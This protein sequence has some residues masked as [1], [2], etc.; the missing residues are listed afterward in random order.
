MKT[1]RIPFILIILFFSDVYSN[2]FENTKTIENVEGVTLY[3]FEDENFSSKNLE[4]SHFLEGEKSVWD[5][6]ENGFQLN[7][8]SNKRVKKY[9]SWYKS[10]PEYFERMIYRS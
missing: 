2:T 4:G 1:I 6:I 8:I 7:D 3:L 9:T 5:R 10:R